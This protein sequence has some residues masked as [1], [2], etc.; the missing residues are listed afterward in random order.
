MGHLLCA[1]ALQTTKPSWMRKCKWLSSQFM[2]FYLPVSSYWCKCVCIVMLMQYHNIGIDIWIFITLIAFSVCWSKRKML[3]IWDSLKQI[4]WNQFIHNQLLWRAV[5]SQEPFHADPVP[6]LFV[7]HFRPSVHFSIAIYLK[8][9]T[10]FDDLRRINF[11]FPF[12]WSENQACVFYVM[13]EM[14]RLLHIV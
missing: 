7:A 8:F 5:K 10:S 13:Y 12:S 1:Y 9:I 2:N 11:S 14:V 4:E 6:S 3:M